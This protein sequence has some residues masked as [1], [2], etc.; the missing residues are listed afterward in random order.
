MENRMAPQLEEKDSR[1]GVMSRKSVKVDQFMQTL[2]H[3][4][5][6]EIESV[7]TLILRTNEG[8]TEHIKWNAPSFRYDGEDRITFKLHPPTSIQLVF[9][10]GA[11][12]KDGEDFSFEDDTGLLQWVTKD[13]GIVTLRDM[14]DVLARAGDLVK[15]IDAWVKSGG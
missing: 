14:G 8:I 7:R 2:D 6:A 15:V 5:K 1:G 3:P 11:K 10:R 4:L 9:H 12:V 13:R